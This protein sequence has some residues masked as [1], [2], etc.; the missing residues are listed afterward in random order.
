MKSQTFSF[1][2]ELRKH[3]VNMISKQYQCLE[4]ISNEKSVNICMRTLKGLST[5][6]WE[7]SDWEHS[8]VVAYQPQLFQH[9]LLFM[10]HTDIFVLW[11]L[12]LWDV[13]LY[14]LSKKK[15]ISVV[16]TNS[17][18][19]KWQPKDVLR[20][21]RVRISYGQCKNHIILSYKDEYKQMFI[22]CSLNL[23]A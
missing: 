20:M 16:R 3:H 11:Q 4:V 13:D 2:T 7:I 22:I 5:P 18:S 10:E 14:R 19:F 23:T 1:T 12:F 8:T 9:L 21:T 6:P 15:Y 17:V